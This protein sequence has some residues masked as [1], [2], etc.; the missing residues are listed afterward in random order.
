VSLT[1][2]GLPP[3][4]ACNCDPEASPTPTAVAS[5]SKRKAVLQ[6][7]TLY[8]HDIVTVTIILLLV[9]RGVIEALKPVMSVKLPLVVEN[10]SVFVVDT[11]C[12]IP[13]D[14]DT[15][16]IQDELPPPGSV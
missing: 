5:L 6:V 7:S 15:A 16:P 2:P 4:L 10:V 11:T 12:K 1:A 3:V 8:P 14:R 13:P 9:E